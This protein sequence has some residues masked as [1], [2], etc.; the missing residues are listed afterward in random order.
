MTGDGGDHAAGFVGG[1]DAFDGLVDP[2]TEGGD[3]VLD[4]PSQPVVGVFMNGFVGIQTLTFE[5][6]WI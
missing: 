5:R 1:G 3:G 2:G 6:P 4:L